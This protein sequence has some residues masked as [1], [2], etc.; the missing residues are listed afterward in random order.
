MAFHP[1]LRTP[2]LCV[3]NTHDYVSTLF[4]REYNNS[5]RR[6]HARIKRSLHNAGLCRCLHTSYHVSKRGVRSDPCISKPPPS[7]EIPP[8]QHTL[9][10]NTASIL[11][12]SLHPLLTTSFHDV[13]FRIFSISVAIEQLEDSR[14]STTYRLLCA[15]RCPCYHCTFFLRTLFL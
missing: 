5:Y 12:A 7:Q 10:Y 14:C 15:T 3:Y 9:A 1:I 8:H 6:D 4:T 13:D 11:R 2:G